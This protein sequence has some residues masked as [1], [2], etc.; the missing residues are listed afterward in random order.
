MTEGDKFLIP[1][2][3][4]AMGPNTNGWTRSCPMREQLMVSL[5]HGKRSKT[6]DV[7]FLEISLWFSPDDGRQFDVDFYLD[8]FLAHTCPG[9][10]KSGNHALA[11]L[12]P[13]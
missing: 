5:C 11:G 6:F 9:S 2:G 13:E 7:N 8:S 1:T 4:L 3:S 10:K 12:E